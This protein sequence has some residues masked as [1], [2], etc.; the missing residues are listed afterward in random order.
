METENKRAPACRIQE[1]D[2][3]GF[4]A[5]PAGWFL[6]QPGTDDG[7]CLLVHADDGLIWGAVQGKSII[8]SHK[9]FGAE[10]SPELRATTI[11][12]ARLFRP[13]AE[14]RIWRNG[15]SFKACRIEDNPERENETLDEEHILWGTRVAVS[16]SKG[17]TPV[18]E[19]SRGLSHAVPVEVPGKAFQ[20]R[21]KE[22]PF[23]P[24]RLKV[25]HYLA[26]DDDGRAYIALSRLAGIRY[27]KGGR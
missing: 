20:S 14:V 12:E 15:T 2:T 26:Y 5:D 18:T 1:L 19:G 11:Q 16:S 6:R 13:E 17:F 23:H 7:D 10:V 27:Q 9:A 21:F 24:L 25:R 3:S 8:T 22:R 4:A